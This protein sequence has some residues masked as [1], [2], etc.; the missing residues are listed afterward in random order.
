[1]FTQKRLF[2]DKYFN[3][4]LR[5]KKTGN[6]FKNCVRKLEYIRRISGS[7]TLKNECFGLFDRAKLEYDPRN[8]ESVRLAQQL[9]VEWKTDFD[10][11]ETRIKNVDDAGRQLKAL[12][13]QTKR[14][15][16][17]QRV[18]AYRRIA[19]DGSRLLREVSVIRDDL[20]V[21]PKKAE[22]DLGSRPENSSVRRTPHREPGS[23]GVR[24]DRVLG[25]RTP[26]SRLPLDVRMRRI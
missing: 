5:M 9:E 4:F 11:L 21:L 25:Q 7:Q 15:N 19:N 23:D 16:P 18:E 24:G 14:M 1:M 3:A 26:M 10:G 20:K 12:V 2:C 13:D 8:L 22:G 6:S 17:I